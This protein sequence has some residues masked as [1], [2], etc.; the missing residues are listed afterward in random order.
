MYLIHRHS[1]CLWNLCFPLK[2]HVEL[3]V[4]YIVHVNRRTVMV[5]MILVIHSSFCSREEVT[6]QNVRVVL[7]GVL[8]TRLKRNGFDH[9]PAMSITSL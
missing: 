2:H 7:F 4:P 1:L 6:K 8:S 5:C 9:D 3:Y